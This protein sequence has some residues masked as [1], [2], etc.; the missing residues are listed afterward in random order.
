MVCLV[1]SWFNG[2][3]FLCF[4][5]R[6]LHILL[7]SFHCIKYNLTVRIY[8]QKHWLYK[9]LI[10]FL[11]CCVWWAWLLTNH[12][13]PFPPSTFSYCKFMCTCEGPAFIAL[14]FHC[15]KQ[16]TVWCWSHLLYH[17]SLAGIEIASSLFNLFSSYLC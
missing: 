10:L 11:N 12:N 14:C 4:D 3:G 7:L 13:I 9:P 16:D 5:E 17:I 15:S 8:K 6:M 1:L 2:A